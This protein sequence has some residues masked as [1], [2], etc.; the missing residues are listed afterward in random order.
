LHPLESAAFSRRTPKTVMRLLARRSRLEIVGSYDES[1]VYCAGRTLLAQ[2]CA[3]REG[4]EHPLS[5]CLLISF[6]TLSDDVFF[7][8]IDHAGFCTRQRM[9]GQVFRRQRAFAERIKLVRKYRASR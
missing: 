1:G 3:R 5:E 9:Q 8:S 2:L 7:L 4:R 6:F